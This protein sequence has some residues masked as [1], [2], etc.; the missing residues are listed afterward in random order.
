[1]QL[2]C[3]DAIPEVD[4]FPPTAPGG[5]LW[6]QW[7]WSRERIEGRRH[8]LRGGSRGCSSESRVVRGKKKSRQ[9]LVNTGSQ[10]KRGRVTE[11]NA[12]FYMNP[13]LLPQQCLGAWRWSEPTVFLMALMTYGTQAGAGTVRLWKRCHLPQGCESSAQWRCGDSGHRSEAGEL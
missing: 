8:D 4:I 2:D 6:Y 1:M 7:R 13:R 12:A 10:T 5:R 3:C 9:W 11:W